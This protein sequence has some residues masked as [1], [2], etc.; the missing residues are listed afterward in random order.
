[1]N[2]S[3]KFYPEKRKGIVDNVPLMLSVTYSR[4][5]MFFYT[6]L[7]CNISPNPKNSQWDASHNKL[8]KNM[9]APNGASAQEFNA[10]LTD[11]TKAVN[12]LFQFYEVSKVTP[13]PK[14]LREDLK[15]KL[16]KVS[17]I[18]LPEQVG[19][20][21]RFDKYIEEAQLSPGR[22]NHM[23]TT[24]NKL[25]E[26]N[27]NTTFD[28]LNVQYLTEFQNKLLNVNK[29]SKNTAISELRRLRA[30]LGYAIK[31]EWTVNY[32]FKSFS[33]DAESYGD[34]IFITVQE[35][36]KLFHAKVVDEQLAQVRDLFVFQC[37]IGCRV[38]DLMRMKKSNIIDG[39]IEYI[40]GKTRDEKP[41]IARVPLSEKAKIILGRY[42]FPNGDLLPYITE[43]K[44]NE[45]LK[46]LFRDKSVKLT[47]MVTIP[48]PKTRLG[49]QVS[50]DTLACSHMARR[51]F[52]GGLHH[53]GVKNEIIASMS[54]HV[55]N[56]KAFSRYY[57]INKEDQS[58]AIK[59]IE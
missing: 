27:P 38:S 1:M 42:D 21:A 44:Y 53:M 28:N 2:Y 6:G 58:Q 18:E 54:G 12:D 56:S 50:I 32:P 13:T 7:R 10:D 20:F 3:I 35:R 15:I 52:I 57:N 49:I 30:F 26:F 14:Q 43:Q 41:R 11:I 40:A 17:I 25:K 31:H 39:C 47:R 46:M 16:G 34:P 19:F 51:V 23:R 59:L 45:F 5:R 22:K 9:V 29:I 4:Q 36:D 24:Y 37:F 55:E 48:D 33:I 8:K